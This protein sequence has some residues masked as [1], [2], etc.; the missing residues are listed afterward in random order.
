MSKRGYIVRYLL[1]LKK[2]NTT[3]YSPYHELKNYIENNAGSYQALDETLE[4]DF[5]KRTLQRDIREIRNLWGR[6]I[7]Y[8][9]QEKGYYI[10]SDDA[11]NT[12][13][14]RMIEAFDMFNSLTL[15]QD[16]EPFVYI[17]K[18]KPQGTEN[19]SRLIHAIR[20]KHKVK[21]SYHKFWE[22]IVTKRFGD[23]YALKEFRDR[24]YVLVKDNKDNKIKTFALDRLS[25][26]EITREKFQRPKDFNVQEDYRYYFGIITPEG[27]EPKDII[28]SFDPVQGKYIK[29]LPLHETQEIIADNKDEVR[30][31]LRLC[32][33][34]D[35]IMEL[36]S[37]GNRVKVLKP[38][39]LAT[40]IKEA[41]YKAYQN[42]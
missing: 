8:S 33:T 26:L 2:L 5:S 38:K 17:E 32:I 12:N 31:K 23:P 1:I 25:E 36:L 28:L 3:P 20:D 35:F 27:E 19:L 34:Q 13:F 22:D 40:Q 16:M 21:F 9:R 30:I 4:M 6:H 11:A 15:S 39:P 42:Y 10:A 14:Q 29:T 37:F 24:W 7:E 41:H 18:R